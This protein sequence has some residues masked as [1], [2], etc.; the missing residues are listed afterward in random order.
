MF[1][2]LLQ[3]LKLTISIHTVSGK[4]FIQIR[5]LFLLV[6]ES[7]NNR[8]L[9]FISN[10]FGTCVGKMLSFH[11]GDA[12]QYVQTTWLQGLVAGNRLDALFLLCSWFSIKDL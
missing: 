12:T 2:F 3:K 7:S 10:P 6:T 5:H 11:K 4:I 9:L 8:N 1:S